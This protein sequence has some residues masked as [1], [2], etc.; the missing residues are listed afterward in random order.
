MTDDEREAWEERAAIVEYEA[1]WPIAESE[2]HRAIAEARWH[3]ED[4]RGWKTQGAEN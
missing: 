1:G 2:A 3:R 4:G